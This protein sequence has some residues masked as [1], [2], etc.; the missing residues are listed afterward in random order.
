LLAW[1]PLAGGYLTG[2]YLDNNA[3]NDVRYNK[4]ALAMYRSLFF[5]PIHTAKNI[6]A[7]K[8]LSI[9]AK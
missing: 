8:E 7:L 2:K 1:S 4:P 9:I 5:D 6:Q 3:G